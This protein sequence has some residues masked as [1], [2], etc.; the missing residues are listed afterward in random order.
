[1]CRCS[2]TACTLSQGGDTG[3]FPVCCNSLS[4]TEAETFIR[5]LCMLFERQA[6]GQHTTAAQH[7]TLH[8][9]HGALELPE[10]P[11]GTGRSHSAFV[12]HFKLCFLAGPPPSWLFGNIRDII[13]K[14]AYHY[15]IEQAQVYGKL[16]K[17]RPS[18]F[19]HVHKALPWLH[20]PAPSSPPLLCH[21]QAKLAGT[22]S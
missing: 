11:Q 5:H 12:W 6:Q 2:C 13:R 3:T 20:H 16:F 4:L 19:N 17:V 22:E 1:M 10:C 15:Y 7:S 21:Q 8:A 14:S 18:F 9:R